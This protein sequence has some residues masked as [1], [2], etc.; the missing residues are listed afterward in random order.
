MCLYLCK[1]FSL[2]CHLFDL[3]ELYLCLEEGV[4]ISNQHV[5]LWC[6]NCNTFGPVKVPNVLCRFLEKRPCL[7]IM[8]FGLSLQFLTQV[9]IKPLKSLNC[10]MILLLHWWLMMTGAPSWMM[11]WR[12]LSGWWNSGMLWSWH[13][14][15]SVKAGSSARPPFL[16]FCLPLHFFQLAVSKLYLSQSTSTSKCF[17]FCV[18]VILAYLT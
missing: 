15:T 14:W 12:E 1:T 2:L 3:F 13:A 18:Q 10:R 9:L 5:A 6:K 8:I 4:I 16:P 11:G 17:Q 7:I